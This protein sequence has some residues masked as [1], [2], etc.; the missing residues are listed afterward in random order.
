[1]KKIEVEKVFREQQLPFIKRAFDSPGHIDWPARRQGWN[2]L[3][4][5]LCKTGHVTVN[6]RMNW[7]Q[8]RC[9]NP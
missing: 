2:D 9:V 7:T 5:Q 3:V 6:Q 4:D 1:M 8:P